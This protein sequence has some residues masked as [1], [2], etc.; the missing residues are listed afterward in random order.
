MLWPYNDCFILDFEVIYHKIQNLIDRMDVL[1][2]CIF[3]FDNIFG[4]DY[5]VS[6]TSLYTSK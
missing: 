3:H 6:Y 2:V 4:C 1:K 5:E